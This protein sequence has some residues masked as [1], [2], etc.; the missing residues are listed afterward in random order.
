MYCPSVRDAEL[1]VH[2]AE[3]LSRSA[4]I[5][6]SPAGCAK[7]PGPTTAVS[8]PGVGK[9]GVPKRLQ[10][11]PVENGA[12]CVRSHAIPR[13]RT[14]T[15][16]RRMSLRHRAQ[17]GLPGAERRHNP[18]ERTTMKRLALSLSLLALM[19]SHAMAQDQSATQPPPQQP[20]GDEVPSCQTAMW[21]SPSMAPIA[22]RLKTN[23]PED[24]IKLRTSTVKAS[25]KEKPAIAFWLAELEKCNQLGM[26]RMAH[27]DLEARTIGRDYQLGENK[28]IADL[29]AGTVTWGAYVEGSIA[30]YEAFKVKTS[31]Y[32]AKQKQA[33]MQWEAEQK[34]REDEETAQRA[35]KARA[36]Y[37]AMVASQ[38][39]EQEAQRQQEQQN[40]RNRSPQKFLEDLSN[41]LQAAQ[42][43][44]PAV[45]CT[46]TRFFDTTRTICK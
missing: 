4:E 34:R 1:G 26:Q 33:Q 19:A 36:S 22:A 25:A 31:A 20:A 3:P 14:T 30:R 41:A 11:I 37:D 44:R 18:E 40:A 2:G 8:A 10:R 38:A 13:M 5:R 21:A 7:P 27:M 17:H 42:P 39:R 6:K 32:D 15:P 24:A 46:S 43:P 28:A 12:C 35:A 16:P 23:T 45:D 9:W 29:Y